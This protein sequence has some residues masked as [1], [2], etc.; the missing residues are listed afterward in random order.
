M[1]KPDPN[2]RVIPRRMTWREELAD[3]YLKPKGIDKAFGG[4][5]EE[6][7]WVDVDSSG[8]DEIQLE[9]G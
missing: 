5:D 4:G 6:S 9:G 3:K 2:A 8:D 1:P 7:D